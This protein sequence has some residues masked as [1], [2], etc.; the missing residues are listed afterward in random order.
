MV[1]CALISWSE[2]FVFFALGCEVFH[3][4]RDGVS[5][6]GGE[7]GLKGA[8]VKLQPLPVSTL[9][10]HFTDLLLD[11]QQKEPKGNLQAS[12]L[13][14]CWALFPP[15]FSRNFISRILLT[16]LVGNMSFHSTPTHKQHNR[17]FH[18]YCGNIFQ[19]RVVV[20]LWFFCV[21][22]LARPLL[23]NSK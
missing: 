7:F 8:E 5:H 16:P 6:L 11:H 22:L 1:G 10:S 14:C 21:D 15:T 19:I 12:K 3:L 13:S 2:I 9:Y 17:T 20:R 18:N 4:R 23:V